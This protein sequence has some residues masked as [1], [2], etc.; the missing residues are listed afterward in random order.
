MGPEGTS[1]GQPGGGGGDRRLLIQPVGACESHPESW[2]SALGPGPWPPLA[3]ENPRETCACKVGSV[4]F[5]SLQLSGP[6]ARQAPL[7]MGF[8]RQEYWSG[9]P[10]PPPGDLPDP[11]IKPASLT[12]PALAGGF[13]TTSAPWEAPQ[14]KTCIFIWALGERQS[15]KSCYLGGHKVSSKVSHFGDR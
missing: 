9:L 11:G 15:L 8:P 7:S 5:N 13:F 3:L 1:P 12:S 2:L 10:C 14:H 6:V 4:V